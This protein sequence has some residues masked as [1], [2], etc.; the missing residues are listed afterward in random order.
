MDREFPLDPVG[1]ETAAARD[2][3]ILALEE[4]VEIIQGQTVDVQAELEVQ[5]REIKELEKWF[6]D[7]GFEVS[8]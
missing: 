6:E 5:D 3:D 1:A 4:K 2:N 7:H 8:K